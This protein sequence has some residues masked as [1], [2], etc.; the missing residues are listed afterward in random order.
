MNDTMLAAVVTPKKT[1]EVRSLPLPRFG[2][3]EALVEMRFGG[4]QGVRDFICIELSNGIGAS[5]CVNGSPVEG[6]GGVAG[7]LGHTVVDMSAD[8]GRLCYCGA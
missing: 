7:E 4:A 2:S 6:S 1:L 5:L 8:G 3:Y